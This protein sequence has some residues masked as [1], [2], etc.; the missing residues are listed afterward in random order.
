[1]A[2]N[3][4]APRKSVEWGWKM[5]ERHVMKQSASHYGG[6]QPAAW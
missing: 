6:G 2:Q 3:V 4:F 5:T 1:M